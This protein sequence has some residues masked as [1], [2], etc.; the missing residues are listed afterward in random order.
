MG[1]FGYFCNGGSRIYFFGL[2]CRKTARF[3]IVTATRSVCASL[4]GTAFH[5]KVET[6]WRGAKARVGGAFRSRAED[7]GFRHQGED[8]AF[9][10]RG[11]DGCGNCAVGLGST[12]RVRIHDESCAQGADTIELAYLGNS[13]IMVQAN[14]P[15]ISHNPS[16]SPKP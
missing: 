7:G 1:F 2:I 10:N 4:A 12:R 5:Y 16:K 3:E 14:T 8:G 9:R 11:E 13:P 6:R 15:E